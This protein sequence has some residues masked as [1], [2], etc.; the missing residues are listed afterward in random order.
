MERAGGAIA[1]SARPRGI[2]A[3]A[4]LPAVRSQEM[5]AIARQAANVVAI[6]FGLTAAVAAILFFALDR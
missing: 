6:L 3:S 4:Y 5:P 1:G 2:L